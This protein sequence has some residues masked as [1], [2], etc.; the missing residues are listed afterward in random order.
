MTWYTIQAAADTSPAE[1][2][3]MGDI[4][5]HW[6]AEESI[7]AKSI[8]AELKPLSGRPLTVRLNSYGGS[9]A[10]GL[11]IYNALRRH[12]SNAPVTTSVEGVAMSIASLIAMAGDRR[13]MA[14]NALLMIHAPWGHTSGNA[15]QMRDMAAVLDKYAEAM[16]SAYT[17]SALTDA[18]IKALLTDGEDHFY[19][20]TEA[21]AA[22][23]AT[24]ITGEAEQTIAAQYRH[25]RFT[26][27][28]GPQPQESPMT[29]E[30]STQAA[31]EPKP[32][33][34]NVVQIAE[35]AAKK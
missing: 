2:S 7:T 34:T 32:A 27:A 10:D 11:A 17:R 23:F 14:E 18:E 26:Q 15:K 29:T 30:K 35:A 33:D 19:T 6:F 24:H 4:G 12:A 21:E 22:G 13:E 25:N 1:L 28:R 16:T 9:V 5:E 31:G 3:I 20:A 8:A